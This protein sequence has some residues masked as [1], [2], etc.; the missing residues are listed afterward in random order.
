[1]RDS[2]RKSPFSQ[3]AVLTGV[4]VLLGA[5]LAFSQSVFERVKYEF[6]G[7]V[8]T[9]EETALEEEITSE[10]EEYYYDHLPE[11]LHEAYRELYVHLMRYE[12][13]G[14]FLSSVS[15]E[16]FWRV[17]YAVLADHPEIF[18]TDTSAQVEESS[19]RKSVVTYQFDVTVPVEERDAVQEELR[20]AA[21]ACIS[22]VPPDATE[23]EKIK[24]VYEYVIDTTEYDADCLDSQNVQSALLYHKSVC[25]GYSRA[26][27]Y[28]LNRMGMFCTYITG[29]IR[30]GG[31]HG[32]NMVRIG[33]D[34]YYVDVT[35]GDPVF[36]ESMNDY[37]TEDT[38]N[39]TYLCCTEEDLFKTHTPGDTIELPAC[40]SDAYDYY[41]LNGYYYETFDE[42]TISQALMDSVRADEKRIMMKFGS[43]E[44]FEAAQKALFEENLI[45]PAGQYLMRKNGVT[46]WN[47][48]YHTDENFCLITIYW[49]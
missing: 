18:W 31:D 38:I 7:S 6:S 8:E 46:K 41:K 39:Y 5:A 27:Q 17:Y 49:S 16:D 1:M 40:T 30:G 33:E 12:D 21:D 26:F 37:D 13:A 47:Y 11:E 45:S 4:L 43:E 34:Y 19:L 25:A 42:D 22:Q 35:W 29:S 20:E 24:C 2:R 15:A 32:W 44:A 9:W 28:I 36:A 10:I 3:S 23:Y 48:R 14:N